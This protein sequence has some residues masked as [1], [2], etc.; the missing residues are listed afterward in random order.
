MTASTA[1]STGQFAGHDALLAGPEIFLFRLVRWLRVRV[2]FGSRAWEKMP[3]CHDLLIA[4]RQSEGIFLDQPAD[5]RVGGPSHVA[6]RDSPS[7]PHVP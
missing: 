4:G 5:R 7:R 2:L 6:P 1:P 3:G